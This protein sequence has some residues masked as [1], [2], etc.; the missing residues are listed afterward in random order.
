MNW[1]YA[2]LPP[3]R[4]LFLAALN[5]SN[6]FAIES[7]AVAAMWGWF[8]YD[9]DDIESDGAEEESKRGPSQH[10]QGKASP[11]RRGDSEYNTTN[12]ATLDELDPAVTAAILAQVEHC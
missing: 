4:A 12:A 1:W 5:Q 9:T 10:E 11:R 3:V 6:R 8:T 2:D 7:S